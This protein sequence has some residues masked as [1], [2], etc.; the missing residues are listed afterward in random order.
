MNSRQK[1]FVSL[2]LAIAGWAAL[3]Q[4]AFANGMHP[5]IP[6]LDK[7][8]VPVVTSGLPLS[9]M[10]TCGGDCHDTAYIVRGSDHADAGASHQQQEGNAHRWQQG[11]GYFGEWDPLAYD[12]IGP[13]E[14]GGIDLAAWLK[15]Y[16]ARHVGGGPVAELVEM[17][18]LLCHTR[19]DNAARES[20]L[21]R[22]DFEWANSLPF[23]TLG[24]LTAEQGQWHWN[25]ADFLPDGSL[26]KGLLEVGKP[27]DEN[28]A[29]CHGI[30]E[31]SLDDPLTI[32]AD[33]RKRHNTER[34][35]QLISPQKLLNSGLNISGKESLNYPFDV[36]SDRV[37]GC[38][39]C[40]YSLNNPVFFRQREA[41]RPAHLSFDPRRMSSADYLERP[42]H[43]FAKGQSTL[44]LAATD[45]E[46]SLRRCESCHDANSVHDWLPYKQGH[47]ASLACESCHIP[48]LFG[49]GLQAVDWTML[50]SN[51]Q[52]LRQYRNVEGDPVAADSLIEGF[53]P[54]ILPRVD[55]DGHFHLAPFNL[56]ASWYWLAG[57]PARPV[58]RQQLEAALFVDGDFH[59]DLLAALDSNGDKQLLGAELRLDNETA[60]NAVRKRLQTMGLVDLQVHGEVTPFSISHNVVNGQQAIRKCIHC[61]GSDSVLGRPFALSEYQPGN[62]QPV[63]IEYPGVALS[64]DIG[65]DL[66]GAA[67]FTPDNR[68]AGFYVIGL[69]GRKWADTLGLLMFLAVLA[70]VSIHAV[71]RFVSARNRAPVVREYERVY[72][73]DTYERLWHW[74]QASAI[75]LLLF[76]GLIIHKPQFFGMFSFSYI[77]SV[78]NVLGFI[79]LINAALAL[80]YNLASGE[81]RQYFPDPD[82]FIARSMAQ[83]MYY[84]QGIFA[85]KPHPLEKTRAHKLNPLQQVTYLVILNIL[86]PAQVVTG[87]LIWGLQKWPGVAEQLGGL[88][89][90]ALI[91]TLVAWAFATFIVMH[92]YLTTTGHT[93]SAGIRSMIAGWDDVEKHDNSDEPNRPQG[94]TK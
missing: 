82:G 37:V 70:G 51:A 19:I 14:S 68:A 7:N 93:P 20:A 21:E 73:Y 31:N 94:E 53:Q 77:V 62:V 3:T 71:A 45:T 47:F 1:Y 57:D 33:I 30:V 42:L 38:V 59:P 49:P 54:V 63:K 91:H 56:V 8:R 58:S 16:G 12:F 27:R 46:N 6:L 39:N 11:A 85:G 9:T 29:Q 60:L 13:D 90:L 24:V 2:I 69:H 67:G 41:S 43:Q 28:C 74:L 25:A 72:L 86:L 80:F 36:H 48:K 79:L 64:G 87:V 55:A 26:R 75:L 50:D 18:C 61:H 81:I 10:Q 17:D 88:P 23:S 15:R 84:S 5:D 32:P 78:H 89:T 52:P 66:N 92:V 76:T 34:T 65:S 40:H 35:G 22:G 44:G 4:M 83:A